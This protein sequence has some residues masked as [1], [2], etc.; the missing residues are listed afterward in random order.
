MPVSLRGAA[1]PKATGTSRNARSL[2]DEPIVRPIFYGTV[3]RVRL[4][5]KATSISL[6]V[7]LGVR[8]DGQKAPLAIKN[9]GGEE[10]SAL[11]GFAGQPGLARLQDAGTRHRRR[12]F[13]PGQ[14][15]LG[16]AL[17]RC[18]GS[19]LHGAQAP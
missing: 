3:V 9:M 14:G 5:K 2:A 16:G 17:A 11:A 18:A 6:L 19:A 4:D 8:S 12:R 7:A 13:R 10:R 1:R 15:V